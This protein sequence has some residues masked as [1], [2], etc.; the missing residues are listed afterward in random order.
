MEELSIQEFNKL[1]DELKREQKVDWNV[2]LL[3]WQDKIVYEADFINKIKKL[4]D[5]S[6]GCVRRKLYALRDKGFV[7]IKYTK[8]GNRVHA[9][10]KFGSKLT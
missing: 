4:Y 10:V 6:S 1:D 3:K 2:E 7:T 8:K 5:C 9:I